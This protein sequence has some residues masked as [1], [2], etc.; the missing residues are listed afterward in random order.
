MA[1]VIKFNIDGVDINV[2]DNTA[3]TNANQA[4]AIA[5]EIEALDRL[6]IAYTSATETITITRTTHALTNGNGGGN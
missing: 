1:D 2:K 4:L 3:R 6:E 5:Q